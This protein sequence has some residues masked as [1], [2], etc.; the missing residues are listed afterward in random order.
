VSNGFMPGS[1][2]AVARPAGATW[3]EVL[4][5]ACAV[6]ATIGGAMCPVNDRG[7][8]RFHR[9]TGNA[10]AGGHDTLAEVLQSVR[11]NGSV[12]LDAHFS[13][14]WS[15]CER[16]AAEDCGPYLDANGRATGVI[17]L[18]DI[19]L[20]LRR[21]GGQPSLRDLARPIL[22]V[23]PNLPATNLFRRFRE[24]APHLAVVALDDDRPLAFV[25]LDNMPINGILRPT[26]SVALLTCNK[27]NGNP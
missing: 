25:T 20:A 1:A 7:T 18:K 12:F 5:C 14:P 6:M 21:T 4:G 2:L 27:L 3:A 17:H 9:K 15:V 8:G 22:S 26:R 19:F 11:L 13:A 10:P 16:V 24:G 23:R